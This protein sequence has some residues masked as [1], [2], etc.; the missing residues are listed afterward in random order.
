MFSLKAHA[1]RTLG[2]ISVFSFPTLTRK[3][4]AGN[5]G[6]SQRRLKRL[7]AE[8][9]LSRLNAKGESAR[10]EHALTR[11]WTAENLPPNYY[12]THA[13]RFERM[14]NGPHARIIPW[15]RSFALKTGVDHVIEV[16]CGDGR[17]LAAMSRNIPQIARWS[18]LDINAAVTAQN[19]K[20]YADQ[21]ALNFV[22]ADAAEELDAHLGEGAL[23]M[24][25]GGVMEYFAPETLSKWFDLVARKGG[26]GVLLTEPVNPAHDLRSDPASHI[27]GF[28][29]SYSHNHRFL[30]EKAGYRIVESAEETTEGHRYVM[31]LAASPKAQQSS[32]TARLDETLQ[33]RSPSKAG[34][35]IPEN[36]PAAPASKR[37]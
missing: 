5:I 36:Q 7:I 37:P 11:R 27:W 28:E 22:S 19:Q 12:D 4:R 21:T 25:Y 32:K 23:L 10:V 18:G 8:T 17:A 30:L 1:K 14:F 3:I 34:D 33:K 16:G 24:T 26:M 20:T 9:E 35:A 29:S 31:I 13:D 6:G 2:H 15:L